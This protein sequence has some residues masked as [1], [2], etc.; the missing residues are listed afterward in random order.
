MNHCGNDHTL[1]SVEAILWVGDYRIPGVFSVRE[2]VVEFFS[3][4]CKKSHVTLCIP[5]LTI[6]QVEAFEVFRFGRNGLKIKSKD[7]REDLF[8]LEDPI[9][10][11]QLLQD[12]AKGVF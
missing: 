1:H 8:V 2:D 3:E 9:G 6:S 11:K 5:K 12:W 4:T 7:G 10:L